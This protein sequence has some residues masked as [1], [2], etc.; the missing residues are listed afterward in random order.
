M[1]WALQIRLFPPVSEFNILCR[2]V[3]F[4]RAGHICPIPILSHFYY[5]YM[6]LYE[7]NL[8]GLILH[9]RHVWTITNHIVGI[10]KGGIIWWF[11]WF[12]R[13]PWNNYPQQSYYYSCNRQLPLHATT[14]FSRGL[15]NLSM[16]TKYFVPP[17]KYTLYKVNTLFDYTHVH[18]YMIQYSS[19]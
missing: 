7:M 10:F 16:I 3:P 1:L 15:A 4:P 2:V 14:K 19:R 13:K 17:E 18:R 11:S 6:P 8:R 12:R 5:P 9:I